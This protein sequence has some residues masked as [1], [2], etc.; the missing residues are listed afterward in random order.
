MKRLTILM[1]II[2]LSHVSLAAQN[3]SV[4]QVTELMNTAFAQHKAGNNQ[5]ALNNFLLVGQNTNKQRTEYE[6]QVYV[7][8]Q[9]MAVMCY[10]SLER[11]S[12]G[13]KLSE[14]LLKG[15]LAVN[16]RKNLEHL[17]VMNGYFLAT[18]YMH[19]DIRRYADARLIFDKILPLAGADMRER[20]RT[21]IPMAWY[22]EGTISQI[23][24]K[25]EEALT[26]LEEARKGFREL[27][28][29]KNELDAT[30]QMGDIN[31]ALYDTFEALELYNNAE[32]I[33]RIAGYEEDLLKILKEQQ[34]LCKM[35]GDSERQFRLTMQMD[36]L[37][38]VT[39]NEKVR[40]AHYN[41]RG[42][43]AKAQ[44]YYDL[45]EQW[46]L[47]NDEYVRQLSDENIG[48]DRYLHYLKLRDVY[49][50]KG[51]YDNALKYARLAKDE[52]QKKRRATDED[53]Y[54]PYWGMAEIYQKMGDSVK[55]FQCLDTLFLSL[56]RIE[57]PRDG[58]YLYMTRARCHY[59]FK[60]Y[61]LALVD[62]K[63]ADSLLATKYGENDGNRA[64][65]LPLMGG[66]ENCLRHYDESERLYKQY[67]D[68][69][70]AVHGENS[71]EYINALYYLANAEGFAGH[72]DMAC[73][74][75]ANAIGKM[76]QM[77]QKSLPYMTT[78][79][80]ESY[81]TSVS[82]M[83][84]GMTSF[85]LKAERSNTAF[86]K[87]CY[88]GLVLLKAFLLET[89][90]STYDLIRSNGIDEDLHDYA[91][92][93]SM[94]A[95]IM[96]WEKDF[97]Q[98]A[99]SILYLTAAADDLEKHLAGRCRKYGDMTDFMGIGYQKIK[100][101][102]N[103]GDVLI[104]FTDVMSESRGR[105]YAGYVV[106]NKQEFPLLKL[107]FAESKI[108]SLQ[109]EYPDMFYEGAIAKEMYRLLWEP[110]KEY[111][112][113]GST[114]Y[115][116]PSQMLFRIALESI[117]LEDNSLLGEH[118]RF[119]RLSSSR[120]LTRYDAKLH[121]D[122]TSTDTN[123]VLY[124]GLQYSLDTN[125]MVAEARRYD[126]SPLLA[127]HGMTRGGDSI[128]RELP[129][130]R[131]EVDSIEQI[132]KTHRMIVT[133][134]VGEKGTEE[135]F[136]SMH[137]KSPRILHL[138][139]H[140]FFYTPDSAQNVKYL[141]GYKDAMMLSGLVMSGGNAAW[142]GRELPEGVLGGI[143]TASDIARL[144][145]GNTQLAVLSACRSGQ[146]EATAEGLYGL[147]RA[148]KKAGVKTMVMSL[149]DVDDEVGTAFMTL[150]YGNLVGEDNHW[151]KRAAFEKAKKTIREKNP[152][153]Y[154]WAGFIMLD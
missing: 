95:Q 16:E 9:I 144:D 154:Y 107:L 11:Y 65:L 89:E 43:E 29:A 74:D 114:V 52:F 59:T 131:I 117:P 72:I 124:G 36:S 33:A 67:V 49:A 64:K 128:Y 88:E 125:D 32:G 112:K 119:V 109:V 54:M 1:L 50:K 6:R 140:G 82:D 70:K 97:S 35:I 145:L 108:D 102:L 17:Y 79:E 31:A 134:R 37:V 104:D 142:Q 122:V 130:S 69:T 103:D 73:D 24:Q 76:K 22:F 153:P 127:L 39:D 2:V 26:C 148:F 92:I 77:T 19:D 68:W 91:A 141:K 23:Q 53:Y 51:E 84:Q 60:N 83:L 120:E 75:Y 5:E 78:A 42:D 46:Y 4:S 85:A 93:A 150:F 132:F 105:M 99:D 121:I 116:V 14:E 80:R 44:G 149:W 34:R 18:S 94:R 12:D 27:G 86:T 137:G 98:K 152:E 38:A 96:V 30:C 143:L 28:D 118:Y 123:A 56:Q 58:Q 139:T 126:V 111:V 7:C 10:E 81:W 136:L 133:A 106:D 147:Q 61:A 41:Y 87:D 110:F 138:A 71:S 115:Y 66:V 8:S 146:G 47:K 20:I 151:D 129:G 40:L 21:K 3:L 55:C 13:F 90:R 113:E 48:A 15:Q 135:S 62:Y 25:Y 101:S 45:A 63:T 100:E 57:E